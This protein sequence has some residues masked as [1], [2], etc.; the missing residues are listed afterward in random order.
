MFAIVGI[1]GSPGRMANDLA[2]TEAKYKPSYKDFQCS[3]LLIYR[4]ARP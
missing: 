4:F 3:W 1:V 2:Q